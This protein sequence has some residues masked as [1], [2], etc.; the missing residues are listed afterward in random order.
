MRTDSTPIGRAKSDT[1][2]VP[3][4]HR[5]ADLGQATI[6]TFMTWPS[7]TICRALPKSGRRPSLAPPD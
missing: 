1:P 3:E 4:L 6:L 7:A 5:S 2:Q